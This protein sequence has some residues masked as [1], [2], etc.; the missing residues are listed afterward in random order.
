[1]SIERHRRKNR[2]ASSV[3]SS[4][5]KIVT[6]GK[7]TD[8]NDAPL[9]DVPKGGA[10][11]RH[12]RHHQTQ[13]NYRTQEEAGAKQVIGK[14]HVVARID[15]RVKVKEGDVVKFKTRSGPRWVIEEGTVVGI[16]GLVVYIK[17]GITT[18]SILYDRKNGLM[19]ID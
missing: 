7:V 14:A 18:W 13:E 12:R 4:K 15:P 1:M 3:E 10:V 16:S 17:S 19:G 11:P 2:A 6:R 9:F 8:I 5:A